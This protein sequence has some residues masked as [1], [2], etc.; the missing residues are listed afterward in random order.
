MASII[1]F[2]VSGKITATTLVATIVTIPG[3]ALGMYVGA[4][5]RG[6]LS[7]EAFWRLVAFLLAATAVSSILT[8]LL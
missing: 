5:L 6:V 8:G 4:R 2:A 7:S 3:L 1:T